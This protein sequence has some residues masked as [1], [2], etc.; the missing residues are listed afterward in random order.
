MF[1]SPA[2][3]TSRTSN[4]STSSWSELIEPDVYCA[5]RIARGPE[6]G[7]RAVADGVVERRADDRDVALRRAELGRVGDPRQLHEADAADVGGQVEVVERLVLAV[8]AVG[9]REPVGSGSWGRSA[10]EVLPETAARDGAAA[11]AIRLVRGAAGSRSG[12]QRG[13]PARWYTAHRR[14]PARIARSVPACAGR[15]QSSRNAAQAASTSAG[16]RNRSTAVWAMSVAA[17]SVVSSARGGGGVAEGDRVAGRR[18]R[19]RSRG[20]GGSS[21]RPS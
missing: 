13:A 20:P 9:G 14:G 7:A 2:S 12:V 10:T 3:T 1:A 16:S 18:P 4:G 17:R 8:P 6:A 15:R 5:S 11:W 19:R 21:G